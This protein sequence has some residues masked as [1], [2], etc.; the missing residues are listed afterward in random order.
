M[1]DDKIIKEENQGN[2]NNEPVIEETPQDLDFENSPPPVYQENSRQN[3]FII[4]GAIVFL[5]LLLII[6]KAIFFGKPK[7]KNVS[8]I[9]WGLWE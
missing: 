7:N 8:L 4:A 3:I 1:D 6:I 2:I 5:I 9:Y